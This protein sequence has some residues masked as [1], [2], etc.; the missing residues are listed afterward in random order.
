MI[1][2][3]TD[4]ASCPRRM[5]SMTCH[6]LGQLAYDSGLVSVNKEVSDVTTHATFTVL[7]DER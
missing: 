6:L 5:E 3:P 4:M 7:C 1:Q 2:L